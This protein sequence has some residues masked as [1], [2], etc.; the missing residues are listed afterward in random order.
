MDGATG[1]LTLLV[2]CRMMQTLWENIWQLL[3]ELNICI[4]YDAEIAFLSIYPRE[5][6]T[7][8]HGTGMSIVLSSEE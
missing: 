7:C 6:K 2:E 8:P 1:T 5:M 3:V 4:F